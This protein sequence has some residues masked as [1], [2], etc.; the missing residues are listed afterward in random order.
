MEKINRGTTRYY[1]VLTPEQAK[2]MMIVKVST[3]Y[4]RLQNGFDVSP[5]QQHR[6]EGQ[7]ELLLM[8]QL[9]DRN[10][11]E[12]AIGLLY[13]QYFQQ[14]LLA[15]HWHWMHDENQFFLPIKMLEAPVYKG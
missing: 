4:E 10:W 1:I 3:F 6:L 15:D 2:Q 7:V 11:L 12:D 14:T 9:I 13:Q 5:G 8:L